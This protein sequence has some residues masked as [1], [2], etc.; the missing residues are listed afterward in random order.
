MRYPEN[1]FK[2]QTEMLKKYH[3][4][5]ENVESFYTQQDMWNIA[6]YSPQKDA[7][8]LTEIDPYYN[9]IMLPDNFGSSEELILMR[10][11]TPFGEQK[12]NMVSWLAVRNS[13]DNYGEMILFNF[14]KSNNILGPNQV[15]VKIN[16]IPQISADMTLWGQS[17]TNVYKGNLLVIPVENNVLYVEPIYIRSN[18]ASSIPE[19]KEIVLG[20]QSG[21]EFKYGIGTNIDAALSNLFSGQVTTPPPTAVPGT[22]PTQGV[23]RQK[24]NDIINKYNE[25]KKQLDEL[26]GLINQLK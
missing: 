14:P 7:T 21:D 11:F 13:M 17:G 15:E 19:V 5:P 3:I 8:N 9:M 20:Y 23:D 12:H 10:P 22:A 25:L 6:R 1:L 18:N 2:I 24:I 4:L 26:G 16:Q